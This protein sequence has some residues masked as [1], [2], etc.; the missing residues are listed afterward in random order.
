[1]EVGEGELEAFKRKSGD[2]L[3]NV[4]S[5]ELLNK[6]RILGLRIRNG[7]IVSD[8]TGETRTSGRTVNL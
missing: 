7:N 6:A 1:M 3:A 2:K 8:E 5:R 4:E